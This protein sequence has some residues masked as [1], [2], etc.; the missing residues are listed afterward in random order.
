[1]TISVNLGGLPCRFGSTA[2]HFYRE[3]NTNGDTFS[4]T[5]TLQPPFDSDNV[6]VLANASERG[7]VT[8]GTGPAVVAT[9]LSASRNQ[10]T[11]RTRSSD[12]TPGTVACDWLAVDIGS[13]T[14]L[15]PMRIKGV[16][17]LQKGFN[18]ANHS[19]DWQNWPIPDAPQA[20]LWMLNL[21]SACTLPDDCR[22]VVPVA[23]AGFA[24]ARNSDTVSPGAA[25]LSCLSIID[26]AGGGQYF[27]Q[28]GTTAVS[29]VKRFN[30]SGEGGSTGG[31]FPSLDFS[32]DW[33]WWH[34]YFPIPF[35]APP[36]VFVTA[37]NVGVNGN[38]MA[39][40]VGTAVEIT[41][42]GFMLGARNSDTKHGYA[43]F[44]WLAIGCVGCQ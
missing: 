31:W 12:T 28:A 27:V 32:S 44:N 1:M 19:G 25:S 20:G 30:A 11:L 35:V 16:K 37:N 29:D 4:E 26:T 33:N 34:L 10:F 23:S 36:L 40:P 18:T 13:S 42:T 43:G 3:T 41:S 15:P 9:V 14:Q 21:L 8:A 2:P 38:D 5:I 6:I 17:L 39:A 7:A 22:P 24:R